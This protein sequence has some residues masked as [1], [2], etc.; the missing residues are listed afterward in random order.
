[1]TLDAL[2]MLAGFFVAVL[3]FLGFPIQWDNVILVILGVF[4]I[5]LGIVIRRRG[6]Q[7]RS[8]TLKGT[9]VVESAPRYDEGAR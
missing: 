1:M 6:L 3:P 2:V 4:V 5:V 9:S 8:A 7:G